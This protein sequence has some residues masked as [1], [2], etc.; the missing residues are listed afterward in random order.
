MGFFDF[1]K[2][3]NIHN[4]NGLNEIYYDYGKGSIEARFFKKNGKLEGVSKHYYRSGELEMEANMKNGEAQFP[5][6]KFF[7]KSGQLKV[8]SK[9]INDDQFE[10]THLYYYESG[11]LKREDYVKNGKIL[12]YKCWDEDGNEKKCKNNDGSGHDIS[13]WNT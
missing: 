6:V 11:Q 13:T 12:S 8:E 4:D 7:Y 3:K 9:G 5:S 2:N 1:L 10:G